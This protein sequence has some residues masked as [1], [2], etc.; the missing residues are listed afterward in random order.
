MLQSTDATIVMFPKGSLGDTT[1]LT[2][3]NNGD[4]VFSISYNK[5][6]QICNL[7]LLKQLFK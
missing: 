3:C 6:Q 4:I 2:D 5:T 1:T 7:V